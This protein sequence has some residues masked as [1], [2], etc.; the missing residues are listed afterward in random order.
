MLIIESGGYCES[1]E[2]GV[3]SDGATVRDISIHVC[4]LGWNEDHV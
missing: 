4:L 1:Q 3:D 2:S